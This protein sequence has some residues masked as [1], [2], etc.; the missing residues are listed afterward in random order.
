MSSEVKIVL[1]ITAILIGMFIIVGGFLING[2]SCLLIND[3]SQCYNF[4]K[5]DL[6]KIEPV[7][8]GVL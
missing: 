1:T 4:L 2:R 7:Q 8:K 3:E 6:Y 5:D